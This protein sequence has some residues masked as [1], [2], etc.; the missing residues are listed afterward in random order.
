MF[1]T[2]QSAYASQSLPA[3]WCAWNGSM[4]SHKMWQE[5]HRG[6]ATVLYQGKRSRRWA[7]EPNMFESSSSCSRVLQLELGINKTFSVVHFGCCLKV[8]NTS[9][10]WIY[11]REHAATNVSF[12][13]VLFHDL[14]SQLDDQFS[15]FLIENNFLL[16]HNIRKSKRNL[17]V[18][19]DLCL[20]TSNTAVGWP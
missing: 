15:R 3:S 9:I 12:A 2:V 6:I 7:N 13:T 4:M 10:L 17:Q 20:N 8:F 19:P 11:S 14:L 1:S 16:Q 18:C 5:W